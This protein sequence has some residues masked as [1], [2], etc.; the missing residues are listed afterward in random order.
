MVAVAV[1]GISVL[2]KRVRYRAWK[3][4][5]CESMACASPR[6]GKKR[7]GVPQSQAGVGKKNFAVAK[8]SRA[9]RMTF[10]VSQK[11]LVLAISA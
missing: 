9:S 10:T 3:L 6:T 1:R 8:R 4:V 11:A 2:T 7:Q 5:E